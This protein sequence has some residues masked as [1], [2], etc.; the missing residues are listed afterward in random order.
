MK[1]LFKITSK[2][3]Y[4][5][6]FEK[7]YYLK[8]MPGTGQKPKFSFN[9]PSIPRVK[10]SPV[11]II[12][13]LTI[14]IGIAALLIRNNPIFPEVKAHDLQL[15]SA[16]RESNYLYQNITNG[17]KVYL[18]DRHSE[19]KPRIKFEQD[20]SF[21]E[22]AY[23]Q[24]PDQE[25]KLEKDG[26]HSIVYKN[27]SPEVDM[28]Y[29][30]TEKGI[31]EEIILKDKVTNP[32]F[33]FNLNLKNAVPKKSLDK[34]T[35]GFFIEPS[36]QEYVFHLPQ[37]FMID[38][39]GNRS[40][41]VELKI[42]QN[43]I[44]S[45][46]G[47]QNLY[48]ITLIP[49]QEWLLSAVYPVTI[50]PSIVHDES[51]EFTGTTNR[52]DD[53]GSGTS[54]KLRTP[55][56][57]LPADEHTV[58]LWHINET[59]NDSCSGG[60]DACDSSGNGYHG[61]AT[62]TTI[63][64][65]NQKLGAAA[66]S[67]NGTTDYISMG[68]V[69][70]FD[71]YNSFTIEAWVKASDSAS[72]PQ[73]VAK[74]DND[75]P[76]AGY[77]FYY[78]P[79]GYISLSLINNY[80]SNNYCNA[81]AI[82]EGPIN[83]QVWHHVAVTYDGSGKCSGARI[84]RDGIQLKMTAWDNLS[85]S[86]ATSTN[87]QISGR[88]GAYYL[89][90]GT[91][92]E[93]RISDIAR[94]AEEIKQDAQRFPYGVYTSE[95]I[96]LTSGN[97]TVTSL[98]S[99][100]WADNVS[101]PGATLDGYP[102]FKPVIIDNTQNSNTLTGYQVKVNVDYDSNMQTDFDDLRFTGVTPKIDFGNNYSNGGWENSSCK[103]DS[104]H[105]VV[106]LNDGYGHGNARIGTVSG[107]VISYGSEYTYNSAATSHISA[108]TLDATHFVVGYRDYSGN[109]YGRIKVGTVSGTS[110][111][112]GSEYNFN[113]ANTEY[114]SITSLSSAKFVVTY[115]DT[116][117]SGYGCAKI[118][119]VS[120][121]MIT[122]G[123]E[124]CY[125]E[126]AT[127]YNSVSVLDAT[128]F[129]IGYNDDGGADYGCA[130]I[131]TESDSTISFGSEYCYATAAT[132]KVEVVVLSPTSFVATY[133]ISTALYAKVG[134]VSGSSISY[135]SASANFI[136]VASSYDGDHD[137]NNLDSTHFVVCYNADEYGQTYYGAC[138]V[139]TVTGNSI[140]VSLFEWF[141]GYPYVQV[142]VTALSP[143]KFVVVTDSGDDTIGDIIFNLYYWI[144]KKTDG[145]EATVWVEVDQIP[146][147]SLA[148]MWMW[149]GNS[150]ASAASDADDTFYLFDDFNDGSIA[151]M[152]GY[153][154]SV[155]ESGG[156]ISLNRNTND[157]KLYIK[158]GYSWPWYIKD[159]WTP[160]GYAVKVKTKLPNSPTYRARYYP[161][162]AQDTPMTLTGGDYGLFYDGTN[163]PF[164]IYFN[165]AWPNTMLVNNTDYDLEFLMSG[166]N[167]QW[168]ITETNT[169]IVKHANSAT[170]SGDATT[171]KY[172]TFRGT[173]NDNSDFSL[174]YFY[175]RN[176]SSPEPVAGVG[177]DVEFQTRTSSDGSSWEAWKPTTNETQIEN[178]DKNDENESET[179]FDWAI[180]NISNN[181]T[182]IKSNNTKPA[183]SDGSSTD[184]RIPL[185]TDTKGDDYAVSRAAVIK[186][187][188]TYKMW[189]SGQDGVYYRIY[190]A[191]SP[192][193]LTWTKY[194]NAI[195]SNSDSSSTDGRIPLGTD[196]KGDDY[197]TMAGSVMKDGSTYKMW[198]SGYDGTYYRIYY[199][200]SPNG[201]TWTKY[202]NAIPSNSDSSSTD[203]RIPLGTDTKGDDGG[204]RRPAV[205]K[206]GSTY[207]MWYSGSDGTYWRTYYATSS[208][209]LTWTKYNNTT[210]SNSD[211]SSTDGRIP[212]GSSGKG[213]ETGATAPS[214]IKDGSTYKM[215]Y[216]GV[217]N[218]SSRGR[219]FYATSSDGLTW[220]KLNNTSPNTYPNPSE[221][222]T[223]DGRMAQGIL[224][225]GDDWNA[226]EPYV[227]KEGGVYKNWYSGWQDVGRIYYA[228][229]TPQP[230]GDNTESTTKMEGDGSLIATVGAQLVD[231]ST[232]G[233]WHLEETSGTGAYLQDESGYNNDGT[234][235]G[236]TVVDGFF[237]KARSFNGSSNWISIGNPAS[238]QITGQITLEAWV[239]TS[240]SSA[241]RG[242]ISK[243]GTGSGQYGYLLRENSS[244]YAEFGVSSNGTAYTSVSGTVV[245]NDGKWHYLAGVYTPSTKLE[246]YVDGVLQNTNGTS[247]PA[248]IYNTAGGVS[249]GSTYTTPSEF[250]SGIIDEARVSKTSHTAEEIAEAYR[251][252]RDHRLLRTI[253]STD[254]S[255]K[256]KVPFYFAADKQGTIAETYVGETDQAIYRTDSNTKGLWHLDDT[257]Q[258]NEN[259]RFDSTNVA[260]TAYTYWKTL[261][262][263]TVVATND[264]FE[265]D[266]YLENNLQGVG[267]IDIRFTDTTYARSV[268][269]TDQNGVSCHPGSG[270]L[271]SYAYKKWFH[272]RCTIPAG[273]NGKTIDWIDVV[274]EIDT[275]T[276]IT[277][278]YDN[279]IIKNSSGTVK[280]TIY[281][282]SDSDYNALDF[283]SN[284]SNTGNA[285]FNISQ[286]GAGDESG[287]FNESISFGGTSFTQGKIGG[288]RYFDGTDDY[289]SINDVP[290]STFQ[291]N[292]TVEAWVK[293]SSVNKGTDNA[294]LGHGAAS[295]N[296]GLHLCERS[297]KAFF[298][299][300]SNDL[301][302]SATLSANEWYHLAFVY[303][304]G[305]KIYVN[306][307]LD[308]SGTSNVY[309][310]NLTNAEIGRIPWGT[311][312]L[313][314]GIIDEVRVSNTNRSPDEIRLAYQYGIRT[315]QINVDFQADLICGAEICIDN[316]IVD[317]NDNNF[318]ISALNYGSST[319]A[320]KIFPGDVIIIRENYN[321]TEYSAQSQVT[322]V[323]QTTGAITV[324]CTSSCTGYY[325]SGST[326]P[327]MGYSYEA[328]V[329]KWQRE[330]WD[331]ND[332][333]SADRNAT[334]RL[335]LRVL[336]ASEG[337]T[338]YLDDF[339]HNTNYLTN[340][341]GSTITSTPNRY[342]Q[343]R[344]ILSTN[345]TEVTPELTSV[346]I[347]YSRQ[348]TV[349]TSLYAEQQTNPSG[350]T[351]LSPEFSAIYNDLDENDVANK[352]W[353]QVDD[354]SGFGSTLWD[355]G[356]SGTA[357]D[358]CAE[359]TRCS[360]ISYGGASTD[361]QW[362]T[363]YYWR[364]KFWDEGGS[365]GDWNTEEAYFVMDVFK[366]PTGGYMDDG[367]QP[368]QI[369]IHWQDNDNKETGFRIEREVNG[370]GF[371]LLTT[372]AVDAT[373]YLDNTTSAEHTYQYRI[374]GNSNNGNTTWCG[375]TEA[376]FSEDSFKF[377]GVKMEGVK[378]E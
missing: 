366:A 12:F 330:Y 279:F 321:G 191:T 295:A 121:S 332:I 350:V 55:Y 216:S 294:I 341:Q 146:A 353:I 323:N 40:E 378:I 13:G 18:G 251:A 258:G 173:D 311:T 159:Q 122:Y 165:G 185:G 259:I 38:A 175:V 105:F 232:R 20:N 360:D 277:T 266:V 31:K 36:T 377:E 344:A 37:P 362:G 85:G 229:M 293:F 264:T 140:S 168:L 200:T 352:Y 271:S 265:Y 86:I 283:E 287:N 34:Q 234:P 364:I 161:S 349:P 66:R 257:G 231:A 298:G 240:A 228:T 281:T 198:Y 113:E 124:Y 220:I 322:A 19:A 248:S 180:D 196:T 307:V 142:G 306:G 235:T 334:V 115:K 81:S 43:S 172:M 98:E 1:I 326:F 245:I 148:T 50:D 246:I 244:G 365:E 197:H 309:A 127:I 82:Y 359:G 331:L 97:G 181:Q 299:F 238:L 261:D 206:D 301:A 343:Y 270:N 7:I 278:Y 129:V 73:I 41:A 357:M 227:I 151:N 290:G 339:R 78:D 60:Q 354:D 351:D 285:T 8:A 267:G 132:V 71:R 284:A 253:S 337:F 104:T 69:L 183:N 221:S 373:S 269:W 42:E 169:G 79:N 33:I 274:N 312:S 11:P 92:D 4:R 30:L 305:K 111:S 303:D 145:V 138:N 157:A 211:S 319:E 358:N 313:M 65:S 205:I 133:P 70:G 178:L 325:D 112:F 296:N 250:F 186:D 372:A 119:T 177:A 87:L 314:S 273:M 109:S 302:G 371:S 304:G 143:G 262:D 214:V 77:E 137:V 118:G 160:S 110:I 209:G 106:A 80:G 233:L 134:E 99:L 90:P 149:Y 260:G 35:S 368:G 27:I 276:A 218:V 320:G 328:T 32:N 57:E 155:T 367:S 45:N 59:A 355:S 361:L 242:I 156:W 47:T 61:T 62:G 166:T 297:G 215:W 126:A 76:N 252:G 107:T 179:V 52:I 108:A 376:D 194:N 370:G 125:N 199:A 336:D 182:W 201:L 272:R 184:G 84:Y 202:N 256:T 171:V 317:E 28:K 369:T 223:T 208:D 316:E 15:Y 164:E 136:P 327:T 93:V 26:N 68:N 17:F 348:P 58:G 247:I 53:E 147:N 94:T 83:D 174:D 29:Y 163:A 39:V 236:T 340:N 64:T 162:T 190:Y 2:I 56:H 89:F 144:E 213:D 363:K 254:L 207:K 3:A 170:M 346:T 225:T 192:D 16:P 224:L 154:G 24:F 241:Y 188:S 100:E 114:I 374:R 21:A 101:T 74:L 230:I 315:H 46:D 54:P 48:T 22:F 88:D 117:G 153:T 152:W 6:R 123:S 280:S 25:T 289:F 158:T 291:N 333:S 95:S 345:N 9:L 324:N 23:A 308:N 275:A 375:T 210:P 356:S 347:N 44:M 14:I 222:P 128:H 5:K 167:M 204:T 120:G 239:N 237:G 91:I 342:I 189:Y 212:L 249:I 300:Y 203:G 243:M 282:D 288:A 150:N 338:M 263:A 292:F 139:G 187:G 103:L 335:G 10:L 102:Y 195:P 329:F 318:T 176:Y 286:T 226:N 130:K 72:Y 141:V 193:G 116:G 310:S 63:E 219:T 255:G 75:S 51:S 217:D 131:G 67:F 135:G 49:N 96:D 268:A